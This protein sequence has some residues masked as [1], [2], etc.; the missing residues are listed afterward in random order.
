MNKVF[1]F[2]TCRYDA[3]TW[4][5]PRGRRRIRRREWKL[6]CCPAPA[7]NITSTAATRRA[8]GT[9]QREEYAAV[10]RQVLLFL[11]GKHEE[12]LAT[13]RR[14]MEAAA[15]NLEFERAAALARPRAGGGAGA[16]E[17]EDHQH[18]RPRRPG[19]GRAGRGRRRNLRAG[20]LLPRRQARRA[21]IL[22]LAGHARDVAT[23]EIMASFLQQFYDT[24]PHIPGRTGAGAEPDDAEALRLWL[25]QKRGGAVTLPCPSA[26]ISCGWWRWWRRTRA[27]CWSS[28]ASSGSRTRRRRR[29]RSKSYARRST[30]PRR[31]I[32]SSATTS[33]IS[34]HQRRWLDGRAWRMAGPRAAIYRRFRIKTV[35]GQ[36]D[37]AS[38]QEVLRRR[39]KRLLRYASDRGG[40][41]R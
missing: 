19:R 11:E 12:V 28:S 16:G 37:V 4:A 34:G 22:H 32:A 35:E 14:Q 36:N 1:P 41:R 6:K 15:E 27:R 31:H 9:S 5:P 7:R 3:S 18:H 21:R 8:S 13:S 33:P 38:L 25:R 24:A 26:A 39:F 10:I 29:S 20:L 23:G 40:K 30:C 2:R 17:T